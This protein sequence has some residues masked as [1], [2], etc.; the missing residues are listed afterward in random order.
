MVPR[1]TFV[2][3]ALG[4]CGKNP[5]PSSLMPVHQVPNFTKL[6]KESVTVSVTESD[7]IQLG[8]LREKQASRGARRHQQREVGGA[9]SVD[10]G[11][12]FS[13]RWDAANSKMLFFLQL[14][15]FGLTFRAYSWFGW[16]VTASR[17]AS[18]TRRSKAVPPPASPTELHPPWCD[19]FSS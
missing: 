16:N 6:S 10:V 12:I 9:F 2:Q 3:K 13:P 19:R 5:L 4:C 7:W 14:F 18:L 15:S 8:E 17:R 1:E 11:F